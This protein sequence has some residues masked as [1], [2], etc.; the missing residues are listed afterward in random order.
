MIYRIQSRILFPGLASAALICG[1]LP[2]CGEAD[3]LETKTCVKTPPST[4]GS[5]SFGGRGP[6]FAPAAS[7]GGAATAGAAPTGSGGEAGSDFGETCSDEG[8]R[9]CAAAADPTILECSGGV[10]VVAETCARGE[11][12]DSTKVDCA[13]IAPGCERF[14]PGG[15][16]CEDNELVV[17]GPG[18]VTVERKA[19]EGRCAS[20]ACVGDG[21]GGAP[22][23]SGG[24]SNPNGGSN[25]A[26]EGECEENPCQNG[27][28]CIDGS[29]RATCRCKAEFTGPTCEEDVDE[30]GNSPCKNG[31]ECVNLHGGFECECT[32]EFSGPTCG[33]DADE[34]NAT[35]SPC[36]AF[37]VC[38]NDA[39]GFH[40]ACAPGTVGANC[41]PV[42]EDLGTPPGRPQC[43]VHGTNVDGSVVVGSCGVSVSDYDAFRWTAAGGFEILDDSQGPSG[44][45]DVSADGTIVIGFAAEGTFRWTAAGGMT[46]DGALF[47]SDDASAWITGSTWMTA[48]TN[49]SLGFEPLQISGDGNVV[50][51]YESEG[52]D[53]KAYK[54]TAGGSTV[55]L[56]PPSGMTNAVA[57]CA[58]K[59][60]SVI[61][62]KAEMGGQIYGVIWRGTTPE[63]VGVTAEVRSATDAGIQIL[64]DDGSAGLS[65]HYAYGTLYWSESGGLRPLYQVLNE[66]GA[67][68]EELDIYEA[69][70]LS[71]DGRF[72]VGRLGPRVFRARLP[73]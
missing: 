31:G 33:G 38:V 46:Q 39:P 21:S 59:D 44:A 58:S 57:K 37:R 54:W 73:D 13:T 15:A 8:E 26:G 19:C 69:Q 51:G 70:G 28:E 23:G 62:G 60:G 12:C 20:G 29:D 4:G 50:V 36:P 34:C 55:E 61:G 32:N 24:S 43:N 53:T 68:L 1:A 27:G 25:E 22:S 5:G 41:T 56:P 2:S 11:L 9:H 16:F 3:C 18:L 52:A 63:S 64:T 7:K 49:Q 45:L 47:F 6:G 14:A 67:V 66:S 48:S 30:C 65:F 42:V 17:C 10:W 72:V 35:S 71:G 40:C